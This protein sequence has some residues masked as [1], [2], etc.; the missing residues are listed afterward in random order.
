MPICRILEDGVAPPGLDA[1]ETDRAVLGELQ[2][3]EDDDRRDGEARV[4]A[5][6]QDVC[7]RSF[8]LEKNDVSNKRGTDSCTLSTR[9]SCGDG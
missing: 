3:E 2:A 1:V 5:G 7:L 4:E 6:G 8:G 9:R